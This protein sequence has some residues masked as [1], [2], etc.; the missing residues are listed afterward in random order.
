MVPLGR[1]RRPFRGALCHGK[2][3]DQP[4]RATTCANTRSAPYFPRGDDRAAPQKPDQP[5]K[6]PTNLGVQ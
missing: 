5:Y 4:G 3:V 1:D 2:P 6:P